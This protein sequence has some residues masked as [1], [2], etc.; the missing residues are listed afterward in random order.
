MTDEVLTLIVANTLSLNESNYSS[1]ASGPPS[2]AREGSK[3][4]EGGEGLLILVQ[5]LRSGVFLVVILEQSTPRFFTS[6]I[7]L[8]VILERSEGSRGKPA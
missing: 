5:I 3:T 6:P 8:A 1:T 7:S 4:A 2:L